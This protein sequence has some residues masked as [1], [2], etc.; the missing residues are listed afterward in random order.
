MS[1]RHTATLYP[2]VSG[3]TSNKAST[4]HRVRPWSTAP[5]LLI[6]YTGKFWLLTAVYNRYKTFKFTAKQLQIIL[7]IQLR[8]L[9]I[10]VFNAANDRN[11]HD[12]QS[13][14]S[15]KTQLEILCDLIIIL[16][17][18]RRC[19]L[20]FP[21]LSLSLSRL[22]VC[23][24][25]KERIEVR[26]L[27]TRLSALVPLYSCTEHSLCIGKKKAV[28]DDFII[29]IKAATS[30]YAFNYEATVG[31]TEDRRRLW[32]SLLETT[33]LCGNVDGLN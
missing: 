25:S 26:P 21:P 18:N 19:P 6:P 20:S 5:L 13:S 22:S 32:I 17:H 29:D 30:A 2:R 33:S 4:L 14:F 10:L 27:C 11:I 15:H 1:E 23:V 12:F 7:Q 31:S 9:Q 28:N 3:Y 16:N 8:R 24:K